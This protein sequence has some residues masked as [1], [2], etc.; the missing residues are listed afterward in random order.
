MVI[1]EESAIV[2]WINE[3]HT[4]PITH[5]HLSKDGLRPNTQVKQMIQEF[6]NKVRQRNYQFKQNIDVKKGKR[7]VFQATGKM[8]FEAEWLSKTV[9]PK[10]HFMLN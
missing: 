4:S 5:E 10:I 8:L 9:G 1:H 3:N 7:T 2:K 6:E